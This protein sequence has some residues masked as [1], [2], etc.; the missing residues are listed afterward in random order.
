[1]EKKTQVYL[2][3]EKQFINVSITGPDKPILP[4]D[5][6]KRWQKIITTA[7]KIFNVPAGLIMQ[8]T[9]DN[10]EVFLSS[11][12]E[13]NPYN[14][15]GHDTLGHGLYCETV[16][17]RNSLLQIQ[18]SLDDDIWKDNPDVSLNMISY[19]GLPI[20]WPDGANFGTIC[21]LDNKKRQYNENYTDLLEDFKLLLEADLEREIRNRDL[22]DVENLASLQLKEI[23]HRI[24]NQFNI[25]STIVQLKSS[26]ANE[27]VKAIID[28]IDAKLRS[29]SLLHAK[30]Y[31]SVNFKASITEYI[32]DVIHA[33]VSI[34]ESDIEV[35]IEA[36]T[37]LDYNTKY[38]HEFGLI[39][40]ELVV[41]SVKN[42]LSKNNGMIHVIIDSVLIDD[43][44]KY[45]IIYKDNGPGF[46]KNHLDGTGRKGIGSLLFEGFLSTFDGT[47][48]CYNDSGAVTEFTISKK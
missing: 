35:K 11:E 43:S 24:K 46:S 13:G 36:N 42:G 44:E 4:G 10:M 22:F 5:I 32:Q 39:F 18:D 16:I 15:N 33:A 7:A 45:K 27:D 9:T 41:N 37:S 20:K 8:I 3:E 34:Y 47:M 38:I 14:V 25:I 2:R 23:H 1:M 28:E 26:K 48:N 21:V 30:I 29:I 12:T 17:G 6:I 40:S 31:E 19:L